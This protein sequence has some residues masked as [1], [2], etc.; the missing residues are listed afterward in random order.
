MASISILG[1]TMIDYELISGKSEDVQRSVK[2][3]LNEGWTPLDLTSTTIG[4]SIYLTQAMTR[5]R[6][7]S[8]VEEPATPKRAKNGRANG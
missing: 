4:S 6:E 1:K 7:S 3:M 8:L 2:K 5:T